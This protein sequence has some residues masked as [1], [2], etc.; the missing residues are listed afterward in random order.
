MREIR[1][2]RFEDNPLPDWSESAGRNSRM[3]NRAESREAL[4][5]ERNFQLMKKSF[6]SLLLA[7]FAV[8]CA[9]GDAQGEQCLSGQQS[10][11]GVCIDET[12]G[13]ESTVALNEADIQQ[14][15]D[16]EG[17]A[18]FP[19]PL[20]RLKVYV[21]A[22]S[23]GYSS[24]VINHSCGLVAVVGS[25]GTHQL[26]TWDGSDWVLVDGLAEGW[27]GTND[28]I[29]QTKRIDL[30]G[31][32]FDELL[33]SWNPGNTGMRSYS[34]IVS[35]AGSNCTWV[36]E[37][38]VDSCGDQIVYDSLSVSS[39]GQLIGSGFPRGCAGR[40]SVRFEW[41]AEVD[42]FVAR[43]EPPSVKM[44]GNYEEN[45]IDLPILTCSHSWAIQ[46]AQGVLATNGFNVTPDGYFGPGTQLALLG[47]QKRN[48]LHLSGVID[49]FTWGSM[50]PV[51][52]EDGF[53]DYDGDGVASPREIG[54]WSG[55]SNLSGTVELQPPRRS[56][57]VDAPYVVKNECVA[58]PGGLVSNVRGSRI[59]YQR[60]H[61]MS[62]GSR[63]LVGVTSGWT[64]SP[65]AGDSALWRC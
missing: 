4:F 20:K 57:P 45:R 1:D 27:P 3:S 28:V 37:P 16:G 5:Y 64:S 62:D 15:G 32:G 46:M 23:L 38:L 55:A 65:Y 22:K 47:Y 33:I 12:T 58:M 7:V 2:W 19:D 39:S 51:T 9:S 43:T 59:T 31:D 52:W 44:C 42:R 50:F 49:G 63:R 10:I 53:V 24:G 35:S 14:Q 48:G 21:D 6:C 34:A 56:V 13:S 61:V 60:F 30:K 41:F 18:S 40:D 54:H 11:D 26:V 17:D 29:D 25:A 36:W 8:A